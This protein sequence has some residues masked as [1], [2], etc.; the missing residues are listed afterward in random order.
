MTLVP[1]IRDEIRAAAQ[2]RVKAAS[3]TN[4]SAWRWRQAA[5]T[6]T[7]A[8]SVLVV[9]AVLAVVLGSFRV[10]NHASRS[11]GQP[12]SAPPAGWGTLDVKAIARA[13][14]NDSACRP[15]RVTG[16]SPLRYDAPGKD[17]TSVLGVLRHAAPASQRVSA[18]ALRHLARGDGEGLDQVA[19]GI[20][21]RYVRH[22]QRNGITYYFIPAA[23][24]NQPRRIPARC[25]REQLEYFRHL[26]AKRPGHE[27][28]ALMRYEITSLNRVQAIAKH[29]AGVCLATAGP[30]GHGTGPC[31]NAVSLRWL[32]TIGS[33]SYGTNR[34]TVT[35]RI[36]P[37][38][39]AT[40][41]AHYSPQTYPGR[42]PRPHTITEPAVQNLVIFA[43]HGA[44]DPPSSLIYRSATGSI[45]WS[46]TR[47]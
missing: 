5:A 33:G 31:V 25:Y 10:A 36:V 40:V 38:S 44:W 13:Q 28:A 41:T 14:Q 6:L 11:A 43:L 4:R 12:T 37:D 19:R 30:E 39:V 24:V 42:V 21:L 8:V 1:E 3:P 18:R 34:M 15:Q 17:L 29:P 47:P 26:A 46:V 23:N 9:A 27:Q 7:L 22:G 2:R 35:A 16:A 45:L 20:Y 32:D